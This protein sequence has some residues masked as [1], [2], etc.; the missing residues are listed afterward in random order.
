MTVFKP[1]VRRLLTRLLAL[2]P[3]MVVAIAVGRAG[4]DAL[5]VASQVVLSI[6]LPFVTF[7]LLWCTSSK[8]IMTVKRTGEQTSDDVDSSSSKVDVE[9]KS[10]AGPDME[11]DGAVD[12]VDYSNNKLVIGIGAAIWLLV[13]AANVYVLVELGM[14]A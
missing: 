14:N 2:I 8:A 5:L 10:S 9:G 12:S 7:P 4:I 6:C 13:V 11:K 1:V 3:S